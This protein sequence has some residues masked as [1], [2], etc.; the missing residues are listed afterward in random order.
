M[1]FGHT[2]PKPGAQKRLNKLNTSGLGRSLV[3][4]KANAAKNLGT[5]DRHTTDMDSSHTQ[6]Q[7]VTQE[8]ALDEF[9][10]TAELADQD[11]TTER[12]ANIKI[13]QA[14]NNSTENQYL[15]TD[16]QKDE[17]VQKHYENAGKLTVP[18]RPKWNKDMSAEQL[19]RLEREAFLNWRRSLA[20]LQENNDLLL[21]PFERNIQVWRQLW[22]VIERS[23]LVV[24]IVDARNPLLFRSVDLDRYVHELGANKKTLLLVNKADLLSREQRQAW[25]DYFKKEGI[26]YVFSSAKIALDN[27][28]LDKESKPVEPSDTYVIPIEDLET[29][30]INSAP[31]VGDRQV[32]VGLVGYPNVGK[33]STINALIGAKKVSVSSTPGKTKHFQTIKLSDELML[34]DCPGLVFPNFAQ[35]NGDLVCNGVLPIDQLREHIGPVALICQRIPKYFIEAVYGI[36]IYTVPIADGGTGVPTPT[37][38]LSSYARS[39]GYTRTGG[40][41]DTSRA[42][43]LI[44]KDYVNGKLLY[45]E[46]PPGYEGDFNKGKY[47]VENLPDARQAQ[48]MQNFPANSDPAAIDLAQAMGELKFSDYDATQGSSGKMKANF[49][50]E[51]LGDELDQE[52]FGGPNVRGI[53]KLPPHLQKA[54]AGNSKKHFKGRKDKN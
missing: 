27:Q 13:I 50:P 10:S 34:C 40:G 48:I 37:E 9:L 7:S 5:S 18:R 28:E 6:L 11:F 23:D 1:A 4:N 2:G 47:G 36:H 19:D 41:E 51:T 46:A 12:T 53:T 32:Q 49:R 38:L 30:L 52:F 16:E 26:D 35:T 45:C 15:L 14:G 44:L 29:L 20:D 39:R 22:R 3:R 8:R 33:S 31:D 42:A 17:I 24:Q 25:A 43:R 54:A 21:T